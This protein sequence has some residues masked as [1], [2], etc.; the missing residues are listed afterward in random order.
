MT[1]RK[2]SNEFYRNNKRIPRKK[3]PPSRKCRW[4][5]TSY[6]EA[7]L[8]SL[9]KLIIWNNSHFVIWQIK[10]E[11]SGFK[12]DEHQQGL[13]LGAFFWLH[14]LLQLPGGILAAK[15]GTKMIFGYANLVGCLL[16]CLMPIAAY[17]D[18]HLMI[19]LRVLQGIICSAAW[20]SMHHM[21]VDLCQTFSTL[22]GWRY[23][24]EI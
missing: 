8:S 22:F 23:N 24:N 3:D 10:Y 21:W 20:P 12:W 2:L 11:R 7:P 19:F 4:R 17:L 16:C 5:V 9:V 1:P 15:Y 13:V 14:F 6:T 18:Y